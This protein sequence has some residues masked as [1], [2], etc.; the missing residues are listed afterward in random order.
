MSEQSVRWLLRVRT[1]TNTFTGNEE[2]EFSVYRRSQG[3]QR[4][5]LLILQFQT[6]RKFLNNRHS[7]HVTH[8]YRPIVSCHD[9]LG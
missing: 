2:I 8:F 1:V 7:Y 5:E 9:Q 4:G 3:T 6:I